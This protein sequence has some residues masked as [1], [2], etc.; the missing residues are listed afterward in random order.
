MESPGINTPGR[1]AQDRP[2]E[3]GAAA[4]RRLHFPQC[5]AAPT[6]PFTAGTTLPMTPRV[7]SAFTRGALRG[8]ARWDLQSRGDA[9]RRHGGV[10]GAGGAGPSPARP[11]R[12]RG[13]LAGPAATAPC[14]PATAAPPPPASSAPRCPPPAEVTALRPRPSLP[15]PGGV[16]PSGRGP[17]G[18]PAP[19]LPLSRCDS[20]GARRPFP[21]SL[22]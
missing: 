17:E 15:G 20:G 21:F 11:C 18:A 10:T 6:H 22:L 5:H 3:P 16:G 8:D 2:R 13:E 4:G 7:A 19:A 12:R 14:P 1:C 9:R